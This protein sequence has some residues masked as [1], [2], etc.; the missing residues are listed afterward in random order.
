[1]WIGTKTKVVY[2]GSAIDC[3]RP[4][5]IKKFEVYGRV[6]C[7][8]YLCKFRCLIRENEVSIQGRASV[9]EEESGGREDQEEIP[10]ESASESNVTTYFR[11]V[12]VAN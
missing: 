1:M 4:I 5:T 3:F 9:R 2:E 6:Y 8:Q 10:R 7:S 11:D 12:N